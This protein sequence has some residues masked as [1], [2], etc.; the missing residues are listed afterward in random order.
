MAGVLKSS[1][2]LI[3]CEGTLLK[4]LNR[5]SFCAFGYYYEAKSIDHFYKDFAY[6][7]TEGS[8]IFLLCSFLEY[9]TQSHN[10]IPTRRETATMCLAA[11]KLLGQGPL[12]NFLAAPT[13]I[14][15]HVYYMCFL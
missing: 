2:H 9:P 12:G 3:L 5:G 1:V 13:G 6:G 8:L 11:E 4:L 10:P 14:V 7:S 15:L